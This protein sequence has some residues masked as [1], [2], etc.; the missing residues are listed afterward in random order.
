MG[1]LFTGKLSYRANFRRDAIIET[2]RALWTI[3]RKG[4]FKRTY[5][6]NKGEDETIGMHDTPNM[7]KGCRLENG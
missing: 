1:N 6:L 2:P 4:W 3:K 7:E 5:L